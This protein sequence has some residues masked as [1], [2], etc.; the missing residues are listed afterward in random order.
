MSPITLDTKA[1]RG[2]LSIGNTK[3]YELIKSGDLTVVKIGRKTLITVASIEA[4][5]AK[6]T[7]RGERG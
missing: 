3:L 5:I 4:L 6:S 1:A 7:V 2:V